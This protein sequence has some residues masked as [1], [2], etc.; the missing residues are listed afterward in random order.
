MAMIKKIINLLTGR[1]ILD[2]AS[3]FDDHPK[4][5]HISDTPSQFYSELKRILK[6]LEPDYIIHT[7][8]LAD[9]IKIGLYQSSFHRYKHEVSI[10]LRILQESKAKKIVLT[11][12]NHDDYDFIKK[13]SGRL[14]VFEGPGKLELEGKNVA[15]SHYYSDLKDLPADV[16][17]YGHDLNTSED[18]KNT[19][20]DLNGIVSMSL[21]DLVTLEVK[22]IEYPFGTDN[23]RLNRN[24]LGI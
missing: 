13:N 7:G 22:R 17:L 6:E 2:H 9:N 5:L 12:G 21:I 24:K 19:E 8:D 1:T 3:T 18:D 20:R 23:S 15:F 4:L 11:L 16:R 14:M 10:L